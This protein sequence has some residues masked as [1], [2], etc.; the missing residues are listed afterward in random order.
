ML[1]C[2]L[3]GKIALVKNLAFGSI[4]DSHTGRLFSVN[5]SVKI[6][7]KGWQI[8]KFKKN[9]HFHFH[10]FPKLSPQPILLTF[11]SK[12]PRGNLRLGETAGARKKV[13]AGSQGPSFCFMFLGV[14]LHSEAQAPPAMTGSRRPH[15]VILG[16]FGHF[17]AQ[18]G[19]LDQ[20]TASI[21]RDYQRVL[22]KPGTKR[23]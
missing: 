4:S 17:L 21:D 6:Q 16:H 13:E 18:I 2:I 1:I 10:F 9:F 7:K 19:R 14:S 20:V 5:I 3:R 23:H 8:P 11:S 12:A 15:W 22:S